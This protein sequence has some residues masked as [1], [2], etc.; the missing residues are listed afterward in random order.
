[1]GSS[2]RSSSSCRR[3]RAPP[4]HAALSSCCVTGSLDSGQPCGAEVKLAGTP[5][6]LAQPEQPNGCAVV[7]AT[8]VFGWTLTNTRNIGAYCLFI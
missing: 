2:G 7:I 3:T 5:C 4:L 6:Y 8:D 1:M